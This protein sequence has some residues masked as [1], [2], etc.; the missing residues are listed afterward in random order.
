MR[1]DRYFLSGMEVVSPVCVWES[2]SDDLKRQTSFRSSKQVMQ[3]AWAVSEKCDCAA[4][5]LNCFRLDVDFKAF[6]FILLSRFHFSCFR[7]LLVTS[8]YLLQCGWFLFSPSALTHGGSGGCIWGW[9]LCF[10]VTG[11]TGTLP[12]GVFTWT[13]LPWRASKSQTHLASFAQPA[14]TAP[15][16]QQYGRDQSLLNMQRTKE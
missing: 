16:P 9:G 10:L 14:I 2:E 5:A 13:L 4:L 6:F 3:E 7:L 1:A 12:D 8:Q 11:P 15:P